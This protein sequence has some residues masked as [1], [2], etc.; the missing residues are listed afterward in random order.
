MGDIMSKCLCCGFHTNGCTCT[1]PDG[2]L[3]REIGRLRGIITEIAELIFYE[4]PLSQQDMWLEDRYEDGLYTKPNTC[5]C[6]DI[7]LLEGCC[8]E[9]GGTFD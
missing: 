2:N 3:M 5:P 9:C 1:I 6:C 7:E 8:R 4:E